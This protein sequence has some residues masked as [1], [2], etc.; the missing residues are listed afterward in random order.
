M[1]R[2]G[3]GLLAIGLVCGAVARADLD[4]GTWAPDLEASD[5]VNTDGQSLSIAECR[6]MVVVLFFW[7]SASEG[8]DQLL[9]YFTLM[10]AT[11]GKGAG[12]YFVGL[13][14]SDRKGIAD[15]L[16]RQKVF[17]PVG[18]EAK[19]TVDEYKITQF[20][21]L[22][23]IDPT[24]K[25]AWVGWPGKQ[26]SKGF[27]DELNKVLEDKPPTRTHPEEA[28][29]AQELLTQ[30]REAL[31]DENYRDAHEAASKALDHALAGDLLKTYCQDMV[32]LVESIARDELA[33]A[34]RAVDEKNYEDAVTRLLNV[35]RDFQGVDVAVSARK[36]LDLLKKKQG[37]IETILKQHEDA[38][39]AE[40]T[41]AGA[42]D[43]LRARKF[44]PAVDKLES[45]VN[46]Y[47]ATATATK[48][49]TILDRIHKN[50]AIMAYVRD[51]KASKECLM[52]LSQAEAFSQ[53][54]KADRARELLREIIDKYG[55]TTYATEA[56]KRL[57]R[58]P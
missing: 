55:D 32:D 2:F 5:W 16:K 41:L 14:D 9:P 24:G 23:I 46:D 28:A 18:A 33:C 42:I 47:S 30:A 49:Q 31:R 17:F 58:M 8:L 36:K 43:D 25:V 53:T 20:P 37:E 39:T 13:T 29:K 10:N 19:K 22:V 44:G 21:R 7:S 40:M 12:V 3:L 45:I 15:A 48:A 57:A 6:G 27:T 54:G 52:L 34:D 11:Y 38:G 56:A 1:L 35:R 4:V 26:G 50:D 51:Y